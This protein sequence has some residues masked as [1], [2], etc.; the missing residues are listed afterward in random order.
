[1]VIARIKSCHFINRASSKL[2]Y[3]LVYE[4][5]VLLVKT[6]IC[7]C[8]HICDKPGVLTVKTVCSIKSMLLLQRF[9][10]PFHFKIGSMRREYELFNI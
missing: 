2:E 9:K 1:M 6:E 7:V 3:S 4:S 10:L 5:L 8:V